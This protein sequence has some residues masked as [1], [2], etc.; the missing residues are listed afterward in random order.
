MSTGK[1]EEEEKEEALVHH[2]DGYADVCCC[3]RDV[4]SSEWERIIARKH[5]EGRDMLAPAEIE[6]IVASLREDIPDEL[7]SFFTERFCAILTAG[8]DTE[9]KKRDGDQ[10]A[11]EMVRRMQLYH[12]CV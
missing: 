8:N 11:I 9:G 3:G 10:L 7:W 6:I 12:E 2:Q 4:P 1:E 5:E